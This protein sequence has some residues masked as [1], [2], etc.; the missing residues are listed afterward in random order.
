[1]EVPL[2]AILL[3]RRGDPAVRDRLLAG[4]VRPGGERREAA[5]LFA[6]LRGFTGMIQAEAPEV[7]VPKLIAVSAADLP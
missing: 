3:A 6:D 7:V 5:V 1:M 2:A 4:G